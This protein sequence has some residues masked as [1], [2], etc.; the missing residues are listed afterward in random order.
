M[1][2]RI[3]W[4]GGARIAVTVSTVFEEGSEHSPARGDAH[5]ETMTESGSPVTTPGVRDLLTESIYEYGSRA[6]IWRLLG[7]FERYQVPVT[8]WC[9]GM[10]LENSP[11]VARAIGQSGHEVAAHGYRWIEQHIME[12]EEERRFIRRAVAAI[13]ATTGQQPQ[14]WLCRA[15]RPSEH[16]LELVAE[17]GF[18]YSSDTTADDLPYTLQVA[19]RTLVMVPYPTDISNDTYMWKRGMTPLEWAENLKATFDLLYEEGRE[20]PKMMSVAMHP[21]ISGRATRASGIDRFLRY[22]RG[23]PGVWFARRVEIARYWLENYV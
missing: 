14:G 5:A 2:Q 9:A 19:G 21:R 4:P 10:A 15:V 20:A 23:F 17:E 18:L 8:L 1:K 12:R 16:T 11:E 3:G 22:A 13:K 6:G 7:I